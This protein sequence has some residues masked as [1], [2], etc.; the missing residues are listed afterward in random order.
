MYAKVNR[1]AGCAVR[2]LEEIEFNKFENNSE[3]KMF[4]NGNNFQN[5]TNISKVSSKLCICILFAWCTLGK[6]S[7]KLIKN[8]F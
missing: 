6:S 5:N 4:Q 7:G 3:I 1:L 8:I 2:D